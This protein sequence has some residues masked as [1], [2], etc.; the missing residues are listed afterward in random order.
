M[1]TPPVEYRIALEQEQVVSTTSAKSGWKR[2]NDLQGRRFGWLTVVSRFGRTKSNK[3]TWSCVCDCGKTRVI[4]GSDLLS[5]GTKSCGCYA[6]TKT[7]MKNLQGKR[8]GRLSV[9]RRFGSTRHQKVTW[10]CDCDCGKTSVVTGALLLRGHTTS[11]GCYSLEQ[12]PLRC[13]TH[14]QTKGKKP[15]KAYLCWAGMVQRC[16]NPKSEYWYLYGGRGIQVCPDWLNFENFYADMGDP[17]KGKSLD[18]IEANGNYEKLNCR[19][20]TAKEQAR[21][22]RVRSDSKTGRKGV[23]IYRNAYIS[24]IFANGKAVVLGHF[25]L[26][27]EGLEA[28]SNIYDF[29]ADLYFGEFA[30]LNK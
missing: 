27:P 29:A 3:V 19:Y 17:P 30:W 11:C 1:P 5:G 15:T 21:N 7:T 8:F 26:T 24:Q 22:R 16:T 10:L 25:P 13:L 4:V 20:A 2:M 18:R 28:A 12:A 14:G 6:K 9:V 23:T